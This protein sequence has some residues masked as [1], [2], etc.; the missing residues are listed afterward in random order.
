MRVRGFMYFSLSGQN[1]GHIYMCKHIL[2][3][4]IHE[5]ST[6]YC[7][8]ALFLH[9]MANFL[10]LQDIPCSQICYLETAVDS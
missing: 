10:Q 4:I 7:Y 5:S 8:T 6:I 9:T 1:V 2:R 3:Y